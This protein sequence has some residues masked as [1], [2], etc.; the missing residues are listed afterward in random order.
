MAESHAIKE[1]VPRRDLCIV[2]IHTLLI[3][4]CTF[5]QFKATREENTFILLLLSYFS[6]HIYHVGSS[7]GLHSIIQ[8]GWIP[9]GKDVKKGGH[10][11]FFTA[12]YP[13]YIDHCRERDYDLTKPMIAVYKHKRKIHQNTAYLCNL[14]VVQSK[15]LQFYQTGSNSIIRTT[16]HLRCVS[17][18]W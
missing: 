7:H 8:S 13:M 3:P 4:S 18:R 10:A 9:S 1:E 12:V 16:L 6:A 17:K 5:D 15:G 14:R 11:V 2:W